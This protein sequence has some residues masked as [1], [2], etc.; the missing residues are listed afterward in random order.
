MLINIYDLKPKTNTQMH[1]D[2]HLNK[3][4][5]EAAQCL[6]A[7][8]IRQGFTMPWKMPRG[9][10]AY[11]LWAEKSKE[12]FEYIV[13]YVWRL[14]TEWRMRTGKQKHHGSYTVLLDIPDVLHD[15]YMKL[16]SKGL[17]L[18]SF[19][20]PKGYE[21]MNLCTSYQTYF[22]DKKQHLA[23]WT[24]RP[25]PYWFV[26]QNSLEELTS[27]EKNEKVYICAF[28]GADM[29]IR[30]HREDGDY[31]GVC[32]NE[33]CGIETRGE[34]TREDVIKTI[35]RQASIKKKGKS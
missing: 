16:P 24:N 2:S 34:D 31:Y 7:V 32:C 28:C 5:T 8:G 33:R 15:I 18:G 10:P 11:I 19:P 9:N 27:K 1:C 23:K 4:I 20:K 12:N 22:N 29:H 14:D 6:V 25:V 13:H 17:E 21:H 35:S 30:F 3:L 26:A